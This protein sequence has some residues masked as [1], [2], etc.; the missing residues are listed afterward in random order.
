MEYLI[1]FIFIDYIALSVRMVLNDELK[2]LWE[3]AVLTYF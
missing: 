2:R 1:F 3:E